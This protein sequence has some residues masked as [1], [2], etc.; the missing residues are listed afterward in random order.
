[1]CGYEGM[2]VHVLSFERTCMYV[3]MHEYMYMC[4]HMSRHTQDAGVRRARAMAKVRAKQW[5]G[6]GTRKRLGLRPGQ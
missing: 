1:M 4:L 6:L 3:C 2:Y 5:L